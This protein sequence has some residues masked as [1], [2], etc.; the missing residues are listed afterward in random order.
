MQQDLS[1]LSL[2]TLRNLFFEET[3]AFLLAIDTE[4][5]EEL[6]VRRE[7]IR[8]IDKAIT[9]RKQKPSVKQSSLF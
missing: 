6:Q 8:A 5:A 7:R 3:R 4:T 2:V 1:K 9:E